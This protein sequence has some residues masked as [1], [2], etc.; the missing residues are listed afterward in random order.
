MPGQLVVVLELE[1]AEPLVVDARVPDHLRRGG[2]LR[3]RAALLGVVEHAG[4]AL[5]QEGRGLRRVGE[6][7]DV[8]EPA[9]LV[10]ERRVQPVAVDAEQVVRRQRDPA[11]VRHL[12]R[13]GVDRP[14]LLADRELDARAIVDRAA[15][16]RDLLRLLVLGV[17]DVREVPCVDA[18]QP[19]RPRQ[20]AGER[21][22]EEREEQAD[23]AVGL[24][25][26]DGLRHQRREVEVADRRRIGLGQAVLLAGERLDPRRRERGRELRLE[27]RVRRAQPAALL[28]RLVDPQIELQ[29]GEVDEDD[30]GEKQRADGDAEDGAAGAGALAGSATRPRRRLGRARS[31]LRAGAAGGRLLRRR[32]RPSGARLAGGRGDGR[33]AGASHS[34]P[35]RAGAP[36]ASADCGPPRPP[37][38]GS[39]VAGSPAATASRR[40]RRAGSRAG[41]C[42]RAPRPA[43]SA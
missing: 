7:L 23:A 38:D 13:V 15:A 35:P 10:D 31:R 42:S 4:E 21:E 25:L 28:R 22:R 29:H 39:P 24:L 2:V 32:R 18:L 1:A 8:D 34:S 11:R 36:T 14:R 37:S 5:L 3:I 16:G 43:G 41:R 19:D 30:A 12:L 6:A 9:L 17:R 20:D 33:R 40:R 27:R 26:A